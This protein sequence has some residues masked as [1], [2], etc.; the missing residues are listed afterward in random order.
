MKFIKKYYRWNG[1]FKNIPLGNSTFLHESVKIEELVK[2]Q[3][4]RITLPEEIIL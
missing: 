4:V 2:R 1:K 3:M